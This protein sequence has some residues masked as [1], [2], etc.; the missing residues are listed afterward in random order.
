MHSALNVSFGSDVLTVSMERFRSFF[1][2]PDKT[3]EKMDKRIEY[4]FKHKEF[5]LSSTRIQLEK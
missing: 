4:T 5:E 1:L 2:A 3:V